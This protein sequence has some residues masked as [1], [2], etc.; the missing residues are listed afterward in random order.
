MAKNIKSKKENKKGSDKLLIVLIAILI[1]ITLII[2]LTR[3]IGGKSLDYDDKNVKELHNYFS[4]EKLENCEGLFNYTESK[5]TYSDI[6]T[7][8]KLCL[9][10]QKAEIKD[11]EDI[12]Y[13]PEKKSNLCKENGMTFRVNEETKEC[14]IKKIK[15]S[16]IDDSYKKI[17]GENIEENKEFK[18]DN[19]NICY[20][21]DG[22]YYCGLSEVFTYTLGSESLIYRVINSAIEKGSEI[23]IKD[24]FVKVTD[25]KCFKNY[26]TATL[27]DNCTD[28]YEKSADKKLDYE[29]MKKYGTEYKHIYKKANDGTYYWVSSEPTDK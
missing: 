1:V 5:I 26:T 19:L 23:I 4:S 29:F 14:N 11:S 27:N 24:Y 2:I 13:K 6:K 25:N 10:Y 8:T 20:L 12:T 7:E 3:L 15:Q 9:A 21:K 17:F 16:N 18:V 28:A 22:Y